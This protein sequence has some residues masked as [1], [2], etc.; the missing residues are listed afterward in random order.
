MATERQLRARMAELERQLAQQRQ[1]SAQIEAKIR[2]ETEQ[3]IARMKQET[4]SLFRQKQDETVEEFTCRMRQFQEETIR[5]SNARIAALQQEAAEVR[6]KMSASLAQMEACTRELQAELD[7]LKQEKHKEQTL[8]RAQAEEAAKKVTEARQAV[9]PTPHSFFCPNEF[10]IIDGDIIQLSKLMEAGMY[11]AA[12]SDANSL[13]LNF[14]LLRVKVE[15]AFEEWLQ[16]FEDY[17]AILEQ[18]NQ[19]LC[20]F[21]DARI[22]TACGC[23]RMDPE[24]LNFWSSGTYADLARRIREAYGRYGQLDR[25]GI[26]RHLNSQAGSDRTAIYALLTEGRKWE[27]EL[28]AV[29]NCIV[30]ERSLSAMRIAVCNAVEDALKTLNCSTTLY[31]FRAPKA[32]AARAD[33]YIAPADEDPMEALELKLSQGSANYLRFVAIPRREH[34]LA[35]A[36]EYYFTLDFPDIT[37]PKDE[38]NTAAIYLQLM[39]EQQVPASPNLV[40]RQEKPQQ[41]IALKERTLNTRPNPAAQIQHLQRKYQ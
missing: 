13:S 5:Q 29:I 4:E 17:R 23:F 32:A 38:Q 22:Q 36:N 34:G 2:A 39:Q 24:E 33:W 19:R 7:K 11:Q 10:D 30:S 35:V 20:Q 15:Q 21:E 27:D 37:C 8:F 16:A 9:E 41:L 40:L 25:E 28:T 1:Q 31:S 18:L 12:A 3:K 26:I 6:N 14:K